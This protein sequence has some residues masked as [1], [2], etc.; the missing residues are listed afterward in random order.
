MRKTLTFILLFFTAA[1]W[2][3]HHE[4]VPLGE[5]AF[6]VLN[7][8]AANVEAYIAS[9]KSNPAPFKTVGSK[10]AGVC[11]TKT[12]NDYPGQMYIFNGFESV[13]D[14]ME[15]S[16]KYDPFTAT[17]ELMAQRSVL[18][19]AIFK[20]LK[21]YTLE[22]GSE[23]VWRLDIARENVAAF[24]SNIAKQ[25]QAM[26]ASGIKVNLGVFAP[27]GGGS[28]ES[29][30]LRV[31]APSNSALGKIFDEGYARAPWVEHWRAAIALVDNIRTDNIEQC[32]LIYTAE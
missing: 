22:P 13:A 25:E 20:P 17:P 30:H 21:Q 15:G 6:T 10:V 1:A 5:G 26:R 12:G 16:L 23:R 24:V 9:L 14:A 19:S 18:Y 4:P 29:Y 27:I 3:D 32:Q 8:Q 7:V 31:A 2:A 28:H 11:V